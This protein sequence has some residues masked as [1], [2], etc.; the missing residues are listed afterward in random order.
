MNFRKQLDNYVD[1]YDLAIPSHALSFR[2][3]YPM[4]V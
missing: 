4:D 3:T 1:D 2:L